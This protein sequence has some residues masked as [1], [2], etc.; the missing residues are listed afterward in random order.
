MLCDCQ[1]DLASAAIFCATV[2]HAQAPT[3]MPGR[4]AQLITDPTQATW[5]RAHFRR[6][7]TRAKQQVLVTSFGKPSRSL[8]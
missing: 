6:R 8:Q 2:L 1:A 3:E 4:E 5:A 7:P